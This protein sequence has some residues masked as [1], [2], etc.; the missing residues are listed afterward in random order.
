[1]R[2]CYTFDFR[3]LSTR[4]LLALTVSYDISNG[5][6]FTFHSSYCFLFCLFGFGCFFPLLSSRSLHIQE[7]V[8]KHAT[9][10]KIAYTQCSARYL[11]KKN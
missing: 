3:L 9:N 8:N 10:H 5:F 1:M 2:V 11:E 4:L 6:V 7:V